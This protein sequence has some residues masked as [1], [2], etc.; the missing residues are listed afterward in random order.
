M[1]GIWT[2]SEIAEFAW[3]ARLTIGIQRSVEQAEG[4]ARD[5]H[6]ERVDS[7]SRRASAAWERRRVVP[8]SVGTPYPGTAGSDHVLARCYV[9]MHMAYGPMQSHCLCDCSC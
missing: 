5:S 3:L 6:N 8:I 9:R 1:H 2:L 4:G 7:H